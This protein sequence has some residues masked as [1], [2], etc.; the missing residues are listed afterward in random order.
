MSSPFAKPHR[1]KPSGWV[2]QKKKSK[3]KACKS[4]VSQRGLVV[5]RAADLTPQKLARVWNGRFFLGKIGFIAG[6][7]GLG[8]SLIAAFMAA[9]VSKAR[10]WPSGEGTSRIGDIICVTAE[11]RGGDT[12]RPRLEAAGADLQRIHVIEGVKDYSGQRP[13]SLLAD[14]G[15]LDEVLLQVRKP[16]LLI[17]DPING[18]LTPP[19]HYRFNPNSVTEVRAL[20]R[21]VEELAA[22]HR[23]AVVFVTHF[24]KTDRGNVLSRVTG[25]FA[26]VAAARSVFTVVRK[27][28]DPIQRV[29]APAKN[30]LGGEGDPLTFQIEQRLTT[31]GIRAPYVSFVA[32][33][34]SVAMGGR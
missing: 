19:D 25:S 11:D 12:I 32:D 31:G 2:K 5:T 6:E 21:S 17:I 16:R 20:L 29:F 7:P 4:V 34:R 10:A 24:T 27:H 14:L 15:R 28:D 23:V 9:K 8:K 30:N 33:W 1:E 26:F 3:G 13:F 18:C 22:K